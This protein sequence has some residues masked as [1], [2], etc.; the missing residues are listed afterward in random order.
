VTLYA[1]RGLAPAY[2]FSSSGT[3]VPPLWLEFRVHDWRSLRK[4][5]VTSTTH[6]LARRCRS[7]KSCTPC[8]SATSEEGCGCI[9]KYDSA[10]N[11]CDSFVVSDILRGSRHSSR[12]R[13]PQN[14]VTNLHI[15]TMFQILIITCQLG[16]CRLASALTLLV[17]VQSMILIRTFIHLP[18]TSFDS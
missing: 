3:V 12:A 6:R 14:I 17:S 7:M 16:K 11:V 9:A 15:L 18:I 13:V 8:V 10:E 5:T 4:L 2:T 1:G